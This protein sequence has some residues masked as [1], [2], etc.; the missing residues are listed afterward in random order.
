MN[1]LQEVI[2][3]DRSEVANR[4]VTLDA[5]HTLPKGVT[6]IMCKTTEA[7]TLMLPHPR[8]VTGRFIGVILLDDGGDLTLKFFKGDT[9]TAIGDVLTADLDHV[10]LYSNGTTYDVIIDITS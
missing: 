7:T 4:V 6:H 8:E 3:R 5:T 9:A 1:P 10:L 2:D